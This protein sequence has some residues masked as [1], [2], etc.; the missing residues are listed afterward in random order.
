MIK[1]YTDGS[2]LARYGHPNDMKGGL[3]IVFTVD[4]IIKKKI[5]K[6][7]F[8]TKTGR[9][10]LKAILF[11]LQILDKSQKAIIYSDSMYALNCFLQNR[12]KKWEFVCWPSEL[13]NTD[14]LIQLLAEY[15]KFPPSSIR[16]K[17]VKG[18]TG[19]E[20]NEI[21]DSLANY[22][23][24]STFEQDLPINVLEEKK[25]KYEAKKKKS[26]R[27]NLCDATEIDIY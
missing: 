13:K 26:G 14:I 16:F 4:G 23:N 20:F 7:F 10:E 11:A 6:G 8:P 19:D 12:L 2:A 27:D 5:S 3:G 17:H 25:I 22:K 24:F 1:I 18:H 9:M 21:A 15:R